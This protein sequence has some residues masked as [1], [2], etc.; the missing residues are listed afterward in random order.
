MDQLSDSALVE[1]AQAGDKEAFAQLYSR[2]FDPVYDFLARMVRNRDEAEDVAQDTFVKAMNA[3]G[4]LQKGASFKSWI[5]T[6]ARN[7]ALNRLEKSGRTRPL[8]FEDDEGGEVSMDVVDTDRFG[9]PEQAT[10]AKAMA[11]LVWEAAAGLDPRQLTLLDLHLRQGLESAEIAEVLGVTKN[12]GYV[13]LNRL[14][15]A[16]E[17]AI[18]AFIMFKDGRRYCD[19]LD[20]LLA[21]ANVRGMSPDVRKLVDGHLTRCDA[22]E[23]RKK[24]LVSPLAVFGAFAAVPIPLGAKAHVLDGLMRDWPG[25]AAG[26]AGGGQQPPEGGLGALPG[27]GDGLDRPTFGE[28]F[29]MLSSKSIIGGGIAALLLLGAFLL[30]A[31]PLFVLDEETSARQGSPHGDGSAIAG[32]PTATS[33]PPRTSAAGRGS[34]TATKSPTA[35]IAGAGNQT[36]TP[37]N[38]SGPGTPTP[39]RTSTPTSTPTSVATA[40]PTS[41]AT[42]TPTTACTPSLSTNV[43]SLTIPPGQSSSF[44]L[45]AS[46]GVANYSISGGDGWAITS[47]GGTV[48]FGSPRTIQVSVDASG[49]SEGAYSTTLVI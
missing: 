40:T 19:D 26:A 10:E 28:K 42:A 31:S 27:E 49:L 38:T 36:P 47:G 35:T 11:A 6:I 9:S 8:V 20:S 44:V 1:L 25:A 29:K 7:T 41:T 15:K 12:N 2:W 48:T 33:T 5:F 18:G 3:L 39:T 37:T 43:Q 24:K 45:L 21:V 34:P 22:C 32:V 30:P 13:M 14:K 46:C 23:E 4:G 17:D 16:V